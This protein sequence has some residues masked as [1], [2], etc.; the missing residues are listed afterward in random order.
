MNPTL[1][2]TFAKLRPWHL[3]LAATVTASLFIGAAGVVLK[4]KVVAMLPAAHEAPAAPTG[5][6][7]FLNNGIDSWKPMKLATTIFH[8]S[9]GNRIFEVLRE[10]QKTGSAGKAGDL[11]YFTDATKFQYPL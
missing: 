3:V 4:A 2:T 7:H 9:E 1:T 6:L 8:G 11:S 5:I 10:F